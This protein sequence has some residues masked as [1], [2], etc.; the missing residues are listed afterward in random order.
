M[1]QQ[2]EDADRQAQEAEEQRKLSEAEDRIKEQAREREARLLAKRG[3]D[4]S[5]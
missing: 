1:T 5:C 3:A 4:V 2:R